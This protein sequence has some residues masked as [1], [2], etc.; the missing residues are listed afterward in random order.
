MSSTDDSLRSMLIYG[1][2]RSIQIHSEEVR[3]RFPDLALELDLIDDENLLPEKSCRILFQVYLE[4]LSNIER[5]IEQAHEPGSP[6]PVWVRNYLQG[7]AL[8][9]EIRDDGRSFSIPAD[10]AKFTRTQ[11]G[12]MGMKP[13][14]EALGGALHVSAEPGPGVLIQASAPVPDLT[15]S[16]L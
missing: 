13:R 6:H 7:S 1:L 11:G 4:A 12:V 2:S 9:L 10:W 16:N 14:I 3:A 15:R 8:V 5:H